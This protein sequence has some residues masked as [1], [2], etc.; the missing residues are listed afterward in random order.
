MRKGH[1][2]SGVL[3]A[4]AGFAL[5][6][7]LPAGAQNKADS[8]TREINAYR[9]TDAALAKYAQVLHNVDAQARKAA[10]N[11]DDENNGD[12]DNGKSI[13]QMVTKLNATAGVRAAIQAAGMTPR[14]FVVFSMSVFQAGMADWALSQPGGKLAPGVALENVTFYRKH[15]T[16][17]KKL[18][19]SAKAADCDDE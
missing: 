17:M 1:W 6:L 3:W 13:D 19:E 7:S 15:Q 16:E 14:E 12:S 11:C 10:S 18:G 5:L 2:Q 9:L 8:D 4:A